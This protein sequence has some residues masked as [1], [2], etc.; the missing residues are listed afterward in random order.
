MWRRFDFKMCGVI[1][2][3]HNL[4]ICFSKLKHFYL[5][6]HIYYGF[7]KYAWCLFKATKVR[8]YKLCT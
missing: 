7:L 3:N 1:H 2:F 4:V 6:F 8:V 5:F